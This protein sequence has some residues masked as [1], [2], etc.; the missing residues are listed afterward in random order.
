MFS[1]FSN[2]VIDVHEVFRGIDEQLSKG[3][4]SY[5]RQSSRLSYYKNLPLM[6]LFDAMHIGKN[7][8]ET[9]WK[10][11]DGRRDREKITK[12]CNEIHESNHELEDFIESTSNG[13]WV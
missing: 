13:D 10:I 8:I 3:L 12:I 4:K 1:L 9:L 7:V 2:D 6:H 5:P 11:L